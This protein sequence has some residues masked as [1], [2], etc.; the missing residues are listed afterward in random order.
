MKIYDKKFM[1][2]ISATLTDIRLQGFIKFANELNDI[3]ETKEITLFNV[4]SLMPFLMH[5]QENPDHYDLEYQVALQQGHNPSQIIAS[6]ARLK[7]EH[8]YML[9]ILSMHYSCE[10]QENGLIA[11][12][13]LRDAA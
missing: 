13:K 6:I 7:K 8:K 11:I 3:L 12:T 10:E 2:F 9:K 1:K 5:R 4:S